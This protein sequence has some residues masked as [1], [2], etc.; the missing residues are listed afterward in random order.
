MSEQNNVKKE[1]IGLEKPVTPKKMSIAFIADT[2]NKATLLGAS[3]IQISQGHHPNFSID[4][5]LFEDLELAPWGKDHLQAFLKKL[6]LWEA[7]NTV[8]D[9]GTVPKSLDSS[10]TLAG[11]RYRLHCARSMTG[12]TLF[13]RIIPV[14]IPKFDNLNL[15]EQVK[16]L[17]KQKTGLIL[18]TG[19]TGSGKS[20]TLASLIDLVN[21]TEGKRELIVTIERPVEF[22]YNN[23]NSFI[24]QREVGKDVDSFEDAVVD[25]MRENTDIILIGELQTR[26]AI[27][28]AITLAETGHLV[29]GSLH[30]NGAAETFDRIVDAFPGDQ[31]NQVRTQLTN[32]LQGIIHQNLIAKTGGGRVPLTEVIILTDENVRKRLGEGTSVQK[33]RGLLEA[34]TKEQAVRPY[35]VSRTESAAMLFAKGMISMDTA[36]KVTGKDQADIQRIVNN[37]R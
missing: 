16:D 17:V 26:D 34:S 7:F 19:P 11:K 28:N 35:L 24:I 12:I 5:D 1:A 10:F 22:L 2:I 6:N 23:E 27:R 14:D 31:H 3:D 21:T 18:V 33:L 37:L 9:R 36:I 20:T 8:T 30:T 15:P 29:M 13:M 4:G 25:A 32:S